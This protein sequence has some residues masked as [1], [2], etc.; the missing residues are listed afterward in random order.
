MR[1]LAA[2]CA[3]PL[4]TP[5]VALAKGQGKSAAQAPSAVS[6]DT[7]C[8][9]D[10]LRPNHWQLFRAV[11][12]DNGVTVVSST[13]IACGKDKVRPDRL[14][15]SVEEVRARRNRAA[16]V[17]ACDHGWAVRVGVDNRILPVTNIADG[18]PCRSRQVTC[19]LRDPRSSLRPCP[20]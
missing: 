14:L 10:P 11:T 1:I 9:P 19:N 17:L 3:L 4:A 18:R 13:G 8:R 16:P 15:P 20:E 6:I 5:D 12:F 2:A 7:L